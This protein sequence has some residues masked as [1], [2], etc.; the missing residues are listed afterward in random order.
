MRWQRGGNASN[1]CTVLSQL[2][3]PCEFLGTLSMKQHLKWVGWLFTSS[4]LLS[5]GL[6]IVVSS[7]FCFEIHLALLKEIPSF[8]NIMLCCWV[9]VLIISKDH[10]G[11][12]FR[13]VGC[14]TLKIK[15][16]WCFKMLR[17]T[18]WT[19]WRNIPEVVNVRGITLRT[20]D[21]T[22]LCFWCYLRS[23]VLL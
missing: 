7:L 10:S 6:C 18:S 5:R 2:G 21:L 14:L 22:R 3:A 1:N 13:V 23:S 16:S 8:W 15:A 11:F 12:I 17:I 9:I 20:S 19:T 4:F